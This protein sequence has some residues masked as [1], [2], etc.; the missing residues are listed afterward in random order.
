MDDVYFDQY[1]LREV[2]TNPA[3]YIEQAINGVAREIPDVVPIVPIRPKQSL[4]RS[5][6]PAQLWS[7]DQ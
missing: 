1:I 5:K 4:Q 7:R 6:E 2:E 3:Y